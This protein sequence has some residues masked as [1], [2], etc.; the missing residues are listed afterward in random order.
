MHSGSFKSGRTAQRK[1]H[2][3]ARPIRIK[4]LHIRKLPEDVELRFDM[5]F[6]DLWRYPEGEQPGNWSAAWMFVKYRATQTTEGCTEDELIKKLA[7]AS[8]LPGDL[9]EEQEARARQGFEAAM[10]QLSMAPRP[11]SRDGGES[12]PLSDEELKAKALSMVGSVSFSAGAATAEQLPADEEP[13]AEEGVR[14]LNL[15]KTHVMRG[16]GGSSPSNTT[17]QIDHVTIVCRP[18]G[19]GSHSYDLKEMGLWTHGQLS[20]A[21]AHHKA[22]VGF[23]IEAADDGMGIFLHRSA[24]NPGACPTEVKGVTLRWKAPADVE[25]PVRVWVHAVEMIYVPEG[26]FELGDPRGRK[27][28][29]ACFHASRPEVIEGGARRWTWKVE[30]E[31]EIPV[32]AQTETPII[33]SL[34]WDNRG[35]WGDFGNIPATYPKGHKAFY[36][37]RRQMTQGEFTDYINSLFF[38]AKSCRFPYG[39]QGFYRYTVFKTESGQ[40]AATRPNRAN[41]WMSWTDAISWLWWA[42]LRPMSE[43]EYEKACRGEAPAVAEEFAWGTSA[44]ETSLVIKGDE[45]SEESLPSN[46]NINNAL[47]TFQGGDG[48][49][50]PVRDDAFALQ[51]THLAEAQDASGYAVFVDQGDGASFTPAHTGESRAAAGSSYYGI[52]G[53][54]GNLWEF[55]VTAGNDVGRSYAGAHGTGELDK[56][57][58]PPRDDNDQFPWPWTDSEGVGFR[59]GSWYTSWHKGRL[60]DRIFSTGLESYTTRSHDTGVRGVRTARK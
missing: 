3:S 31:D 39:G 1:Y 5:E 17:A 35:Q 12:K 23:E 13:A 2:G 43:M 53:M 10:R 40:R 24:D 19:A 8:H 14:Y 11:R 33:N 59:G 42:G 18:D 16:Y 34:T 54:S 38:H 55:V 56:M 46:C 30:S 50:G 29:P 26:G 60:A 21:D 45:G 6:D 41:N 32:A 48:G 9:A 20:T 44:L 36:C 15:T 28:P 58:V 4:N 37:M 51:G 47:V 7:P 27:G 22:P 25:F 49:A 52:M 57:G